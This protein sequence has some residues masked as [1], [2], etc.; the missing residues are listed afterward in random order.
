M[1]ETLQ[2]SLGF[3]AISEY[4]RSSLY[5]PLTKKIHEGRNRDSETESSSIKKK[6][7]RK[8]RSKDR[9]VK[10]ISGS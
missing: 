7:K 4:T 8:I 6:E 9:K 3:A 10:P 2:I 1:D 5:I